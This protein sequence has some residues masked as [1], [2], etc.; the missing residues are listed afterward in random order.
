MAHDGLACW[1]TSDDCDVC[2]FRQL[3]IVSA[4][5]F[6]EMHL[7]PPPPVTIV[8]I[9]N[10]IRRSRSQ[11]AGLHLPVSR[12]DRMLRQTC[13]VARVT[14]TAAV[15]LTGVVEYLVAE[16]IELAGNIAADNKRKRIVPRHIHLAVRSDTELSNVFKNAIIPQSGVIPLIHT[17]LLP[18]HKHKI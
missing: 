16:T 7:V 14:S 15:Y 18:R 13:K 9:K 1:C 12:A 8:A 2:K 11:R 5:E 4:D 17:A 10:S 3:E 6:T